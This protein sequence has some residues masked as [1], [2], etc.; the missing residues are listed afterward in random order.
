MHTSALHHIRYHGTITT[1][2]FVERFEALL[3]RIRAGREATATG[4][5]QALTGHKAATAG[6]SN[7]AGLT[8]SN[9]AGALVRCAVV[10]GGA[11]GVE[12]AMAMQHRLSQEAGTPQGVEVRWV[13]ALM[14][15]S[16]ND[17]A[18]LWVELALRVGL[19]AG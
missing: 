8:P 17:C 18:G 9:S 15:Q 7:A 11:G 4:S 12:L 5:N 2:R 1:P 16:T 6:R 14:S 13:V 3:S 19:G 10:G